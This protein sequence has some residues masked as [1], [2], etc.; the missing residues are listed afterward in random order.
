MRNECFL[1]DAKAWSFGLSLIWIW[2]D[3]ASKHACRIAC[4]VQRSIREHANA[5][6]F[7][8]P[9]SSDL[10]ERRGANLSDSEVWTQQA[11]LFRER[12]AHMLFAQVWRS[13]LWS[14][15]W[16]ELKEHCTWWNQQP[17]PGRNLMHHAWMSYLYQWSLL[18]MAHIRGCRPISAQPERT[19]YRSI[20]PSILDHAWKACYME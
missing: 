6:S 10:R 18:N 12:N 16:T 7:V 14:L 9:Q 11:N 5:C 3:L 20:D 15:N 13:E 4:R 2:S 17:Q 8:W 19:R 1:N